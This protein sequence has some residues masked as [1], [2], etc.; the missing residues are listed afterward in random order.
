[1][2]P[3][4]QELMTNTFKAQLKTLLPSQQCIFAIETSWDNGRLENTGC[5]RKH[6][7]NKN[8]QTQK[9]T[10]LDPIPKK[11]KSNH[12]TKIPDLDYWVQQKGELFIYTL[13]SRL[14]GF[15][16]YLPSSLQREIKKVRKLK[17]WR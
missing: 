8:K 9:K 16:S 14:H 12:K 11:E 15:Q 13:E 6:K 5:W 10:F 2:S 17:V 7:L 4:P 3:H 1:M